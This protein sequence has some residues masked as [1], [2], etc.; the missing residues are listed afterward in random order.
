MSN[1]TLLVTHTETADNQNSGATQ[2]Q[3]STCLHP[4]P[5]HVLTKSNLKRKL[6]ESS[7]DI[8][9]AR[10]SSFDAKLS[11]DS[12]TDKQASTPQD[13]KRVQPSETSHVAT[14]V[15]NARDNIKQALIAQHEP[16]SADIDGLRAY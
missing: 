15:D 6:F 4:Q 16:P 3:I 9:V 1:Q 8:S 5:C 10:L 11:Q 13:Q 14:S 7:S 12:S 2:S